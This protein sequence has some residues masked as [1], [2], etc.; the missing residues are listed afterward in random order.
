MR[1]MSTDGKIKKKSFKTISRMLF[2]HKIMTCGLVYNINVMET[3]KFFLGGKLMDNQELKKLQKVELDILKNVTDICDKNGLKYFL[4]DGTMLGCVR[5]KGFIPWDDDVDMGLPRPDYDRFV[6]IVAA[7]LP[8][9]LKLKNFQDK[10]DKYDRLNTRVIN[11]RVRLYHNSYTT[12]ERME[13]AWIDVFP[14]DGMPNNRI[15]FQ[16]HKLHFL[17][18]RLLYHFSCFDRTVNL[19]RKDRTTLQKILIWF[20]KTFRIGRNWDTKK[21]LYKLERILKKYKYEESKYV[22]NAYSSYMFRETYERSWFENGTCIQFEQYK[23]KVP[24]NYD[25]VL[26]HLYGD[27]MTPPTKGSEE[28]HHILRIEFLDMIG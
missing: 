19:T 28:K 9:H 21:L 1:D 10:T 8:I 25:A 13:P 23:M 16:L 17:F 6:S 24:Q 2:L 12:E 4:M 3:K 11:D 18:V 27:Y 7:Q 14:I 5:H 22:V 26:T 20:G 15:L